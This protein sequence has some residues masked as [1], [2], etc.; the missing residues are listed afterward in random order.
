MKITAQDIIDLLPIVADRGWSVRSSGRMRGTIRD[1]DD[2]C[3]V[4]ALVNEID[5]RV[6]YHLSYS[7]A[8]RA[9]DIDAVDFDVANVVSSADFP[10]TKLRPTLIKTLEIK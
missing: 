2:R 8:L 6:D 5:P 4:C 3:P 1:R 9:I 7:V 10:G